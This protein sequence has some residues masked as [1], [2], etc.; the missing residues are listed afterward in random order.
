MDAPYTLASASERLARSALRSQPHMKELAGFVQRIRD[1]K[2]PCFHISDFDPLDGGNRA[3]VL[4]LLEA[5]GPK[6][7]SSGFISR[8]NPDQTAKNFFLLNEEA[9][10]ARGRTIIWNV[11]PWYIGSGTKIR[12]ARRDDV[13]D[14]EEWLK[15]LLA[16][17]YGLRFVMFV[18]RKAL[19][20]R[21][22]VRNYC[23][24]AKVLTMPH[25]S[26]MFINR[27]PGNRA[28]ALAVLR[29]LSAQ[30]TAGD[31]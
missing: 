25:P 22:V 10:I 26:P 19:H 13:R 17:L 27:A 6:A 24:T 30:I 4:F 21:G 8:N 15:E 9:G 31:V 1:A 29:E 7:V 14:A 23:P 12:P 16:A 28:R 20:A 11:V 18:G 2:G 3:Q 5:P